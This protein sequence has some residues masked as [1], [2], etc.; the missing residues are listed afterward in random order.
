MSVWGPAAVTTP[1]NPFTV[2]ASATRLICWGRSCHAG[3]LKAVVAPNVQTGKLRAKSRDATPK[4]TRLGFGLGGRALHLG[5][6][7]EPLLTSSLHLGSRV[8]HG[9]WSLPQTDTPNAARP[10]GAV[11]LGR[12]KLTLAATW[13]DPEHTTL[14]ERLRTHEPTRRTTPVP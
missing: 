12:E 8:P 11:S 4:V 5:L 3:A 1:Q 9:V 13:T 7:P 6:C 14:G 2:T 10:H